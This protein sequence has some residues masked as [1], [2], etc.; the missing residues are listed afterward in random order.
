MVNKPDKYSKPFLWTE[1]VKYPGH[2][3]FAKLRARHVHVHVTQFILYTSCKSPFKSGSPQFTFLKLPMNQ[4]TFVL[5]FEMLLLPLH[6]RKYEVADF[7]F[8]LL[9]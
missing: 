2:A 6:I 7:D 5:P 9:M 1:S 3:V 4:Y 8:Q